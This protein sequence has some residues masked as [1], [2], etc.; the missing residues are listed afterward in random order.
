MIIVSSEQP[1]KI[2]KILVST[3]LLYERGRFIHICNQ[4]KVLIGNELDKNAMIMK[5][6]DR[7]GG[8]KNERVFW[9]EQNWKDFDDKKNLLHST[10]WVIYKKI[11]QRIQV[12]WDEKDDNRIDDEKIWFDFYQHWKFNNSIIFA[13][14]EWYSFKRMNMRMLIDKWR[15]EDF[16][17]RNEAEKL[18]DIDVSMEKVFRKCREGMVMRKNIEKYLSWLD[19]AFKDIN[20]I[21][22]HGKI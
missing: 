3:R 9:K 15:E 16:I 2:V 18:T 13:K 21:R 14:E 19:L 10:L 1:Q 17:I 8:G 22:R 4:F 11:A 5:K 20:Q 12:L 7:E 6:F